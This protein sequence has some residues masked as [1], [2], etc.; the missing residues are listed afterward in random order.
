[1][2]RRAFTLVEIMIVIL[3]I[4]LLLSVAVP[5]WMQARENARQKTCVGNLRQI[6][7]AKDQWA[8][9]NGKADGAAVVEA[10]IWPDYIKGNAFPSCPTNGTYTLGAVGET[11]TCTYLTGKWPH[12]LN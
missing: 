7:D 6:S 10:D 8:M 4:G 2:K 1:M 5:Q 3:I 9:Q 11:P 12:V